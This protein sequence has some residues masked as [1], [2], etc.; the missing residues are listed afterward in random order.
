[1]GVHKSGTRDQVPNW[2]DHP[3][4]QAD[5]L[6][7]IQVIVTCSARDWSQYPRAVPG[8]DDPESWA[9]YILAVCRDRNTALAMWNEFCFPVGGSNGAGE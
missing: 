8:A 1:V 6:H 2:I 9:V 3:W 5:R 7:W 4:G